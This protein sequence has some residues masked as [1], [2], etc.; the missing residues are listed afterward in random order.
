M[1]DR[2][3]KVT[4]IMAWKLAWHPRERAIWLMPILK[5]SNFFL[6]QIQ[7]RLCVV[8]QLTAMSLLYA[9]VNF[10]GMYTKYLTDRSQRKAFLE[11]HRSTEAR[12]KTQKENEQQEKLLLSGTLTTQYIVIQIGRCR[13]S[14]TYFVWCSF[15]GFR[16]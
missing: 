6:S 4:I 3:D 7:N 11:T 14:L 16:G 13:M 1:R 2:N 8:R 12:F 15:A 5:V 10:A 9:A